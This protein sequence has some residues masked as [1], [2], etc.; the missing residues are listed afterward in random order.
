MTN[1]K[2]GDKVAL[3]DGITKPT[4]V[5]HIT[6]KRQVP[7][8]SLHSG[9]KYTV[10]SVSEFFHST[11]S[12]DSPN[13]YL[14][15]SPEHPEEPKRALVNVD[16][17]ELLYGGKYP[18]G[19]KV[20]LKP[21]L[22]RYAWAFS[23]AVLT[24]V[25]DWRETGENA[26]LHKH[27]YLKT[28]TVE[29]TEFAVLP[30]HVEPAPFV[31]AAIREAFGSPDALQVAAPVVTPGEL[32]TWANRMVAGAEISNFAN[33]TAIDQPAGGRSL[34]FTNANDALFPAERP[35]EAQKLADAL[36]ITPVDVPEVKPNAQIVD[37]KVYDVLDPRPG[38]T[39]LLVGDIVTAETDSSTLNGK[40]FS[41]SITAHVIQES[42]NGIKKWYLLDLDLNHQYDAWRI[43][44]VLRPAR[45]RALEERRAPVTATIYRQVGRD[46]VWEPV[47][48]TA[49]GQI[50]VELGQDG[51][52]WAFFVTE[53]NLQGPEGK[54][55]PTKVR[56]KVGRDGIQYAG[57]RY[58]GLPGERGFHDLVSR[59]H[60]PQ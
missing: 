16:Q 28:T 2:A 25:G 12:K 35:G 47:E 6:G 29:G 53:P 38:W 31:D 27:G 50:V 39:Q 44:K 9:R 32:A 33:G 7:F 17:L 26:G 58:S 8:A 42:Y 36:P 20:Q 51:D 14:T 37:G 46:H 5:G 60:Y 24:V 15:I 22:A 57:H 48:R 18:A 13:A 56:L 59:T 52:Y 1:I 10:E 40:R 21:E 19:A 34:S 4:Y 43:T 54:R 11:Q 23:H 30:D 49:T 3:K 45:A 41:Q 55:K